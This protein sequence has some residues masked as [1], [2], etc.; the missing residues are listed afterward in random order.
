[1]HRGNCT[2]AVSHVHLSG[3]F[4]VDEILSFNRTGDSRGWNFPCWFPLAQMMNG[5]VLSKAADAVP[6]RE[7]VLLVINLN[8]PLWQSIKDTVHRYRAAILVQ[9]EAYHGWEVAYE[10]CREFDVF[11]NFDRSFSW[12]PGFVPI[13][14]PYDPQMA[15]SHLDKRGWNS[16]VAQLTNS[17]RE[18]LRSLT[19]RMLLP[20]K[21]KAVL[22]ST[23]HP[24]ERY[25][26]RLEAARANVEWIDVYGGGWPSDLPNYRGRCVSKLAT[27]RQYKYAVVFENQRQP[28][29]ITEKLLDCY[30]AGTV[31]IYW[32]APD[33]LE[34]VPKETLMLADEFLAD[35]TVPPVGSYNAIKANIRAARREIFRKFSVHEFTTRLG[36]AL[37][38]T[39]SCSETY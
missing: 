10:K 19:G 34:Y 36:Q 4:G 23:L 28:G 33:V 39:V 16:L 35:R 26:I 18:M 24:G 7:A 6:D 3:A 2:D 17:K 20:R 29:Y 11:L 38:R 30:V 12:H 9:T 22:I 14:L 15:S 32:G 8:T 31:P 13:T 1:M 37:S 21:N 5:T 27:L 25:R